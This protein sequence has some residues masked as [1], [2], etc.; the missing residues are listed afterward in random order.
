MPKSTSLE[1][2]I[3]PPHHWQVIP[4]RASYPPPPGYHV[5]QLMRRHQR[6]NQGF[7]Q[8]TQSRA[9]H[10]PL[11]MDETLSLEQQLDQHM[12]ECAL[13]VLEGRDDSEGAYCSCQPTCKCREQCAAA[14]RDA[15]C[16]CD[17]LWEELAR[18]A[19]PSVQ[20]DA[21]LHEGAMFDGG[22][23]PVRSDSP[24]IYSQ[25]S[26]QVAEVNDQGVEDETPSNPHEL[27]TAA[28][29]T[30]SIDRDALWAL[31]PPPGPPPAPATL[32]PSESNR[33]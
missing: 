9:S 23:C 4:Q 33:G 20:P 5:S 3:P 19:E 29:G 27:H 22:A 2:Y 12:F 17:C 25:G 7:Q 10:S 26:D 8:P 16:P 30:W 13:A 32:P 18:I 11:L 1:L 24:S 6:G 15:Q 31:L 21:T 14:A 28:E